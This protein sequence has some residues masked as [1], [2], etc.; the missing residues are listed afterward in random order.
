MRV[1]ILTLKTPTDTKT[2]RLSEPGEEEEEEETVADM[3]DGNQVH[4]CSLRSQT[5]RFKSVVL[6]G[7][8]SSS[9]S[10]GPVCPPVPSV[11]SC[12]LCLCLQQAAPE[13]R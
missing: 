2:T 8:S 11:L 4:F 3:L 7:S 5:L 6:H 1:Q 12:R 13:F 9:L 10:P